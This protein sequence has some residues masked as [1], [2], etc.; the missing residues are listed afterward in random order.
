MPTGKL[1]S[2]ATAAAPA[3][4]IG[5]PGTVVSDV[6]YDSRLVTPGAL[7]AALRGSD[8]DGHAFI[9]AAVAQ[10]AVALLVEEEQAVDVPQIVVGGSSRAALAPVACEFQGHPSR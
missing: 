10:G 2:L 1:G 8:F 4:L 3:R 9:P 7:F 5:D 6:V